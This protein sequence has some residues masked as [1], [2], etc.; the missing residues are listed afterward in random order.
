LAATNESIEDMSN[1]HGIDLEEAA[2]ARAEG[3]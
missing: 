3:D 2:E 1:R